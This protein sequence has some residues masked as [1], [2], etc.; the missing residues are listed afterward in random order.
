MTQKQDVR[1]LFL[2]EFIKRLIIKSSQR[3]PHMEK[4][5]DMFGKLDKFSTLPP[6]IDINKKEEIKEKPKTQEPPKMQL[7]KIIEQKPITAQEKISMPLVSP[8]P[9]G[10]P[11]HPEVPGVSILERLN[12]IFSDPAVQNVSCPGPDKNLQITRM[13]FIQTIQLSFSMN[14]I[15]NFLKEISEKTRIPLQS[16]LFKVIYQNMI[17]TAVISEFIGTKFLVERRPM[18]TIPPMPIK[19]QFR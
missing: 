7:I 10:T 16:G 18:N 17:I 9:Q 4:E 5:E 6:I 19:V 11:T 3:Y 8:A 15:N 1:T 14:E 2:E 13:N 12:I